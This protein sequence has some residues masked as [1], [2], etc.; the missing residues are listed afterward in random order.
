MSEIVVDRN[1]VSS[2]NR[3][4]VTTLDDCLEIA[5]ALSSELRINIL[6]AVRQ[7]PLNVAEIAEKFDLPMST[8]AVNIKKLEDA[9]L[10]ITE[11]IPGSRGTQKMC[12][13]VVTR[14]VINLES[15]QENHEN[16]VSIP[17][18]IGHFIDCSVS[19]TCGM[20]GDSSIIG[21]V[22]DPR[23]FYEPERFSAQLLWFRK[24]YVEYRFP[25]RTPHGSV[26]QSLELTMEV[27]SEAPLFNLDWPS[28]ITIW[29]NG[30]EIGT[31]TSPA[32]FG[33]ERGYLT[34]EW[35]G[36]QNTQYGLL[37]TW[38]V[39]R[40]G[41]YLDGRKISEVKVSDLSVADKPYI[42]VRIGVKPDAVNDGGI[43]LFGRRFG[44]YETDLMLR[45]DYA[46]R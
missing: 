4:L 43:N 41:S 6:Q 3:M 26:V 45:L 29:M 23:T 10:I 1:D 39:A 31:W 18:P 16:F 38:R 21:E 25:N 8:A 44:N 20:V 12:A 34:P 9:G 2:S 42:A 11:L 19:P 30:I 33:G 14:I 32:D 24:G 7:S 46:N 37:K 15:Q 22:D 5:K 36:T 17:M 13:A 28:D 27:C 35:W 40:D